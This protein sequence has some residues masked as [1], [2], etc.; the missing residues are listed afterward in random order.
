MDVDDVGEMIDVWERH[1]TK[2]MLKATPYLPAYARHLGRFRGTD[3]SLL[4][5]G[6]NRG[7]SL[8][9]WRA[10]LG[11]D[12]RLVGADID[13]ACAAHTDEGATILIGDQGDRGFL[14][15]LAALGPFDVV[16]D[17]GGHLAS[18]QT[19]TF[20]GLWPAVKP[21]GVYVCEDTATSYLPA[22]RDGPTFM[23]LVKAKVDEMHAWFGG[24]PTDFTRT[25]ASIHVYG[26]LVAIEKDE[27]D[28][29]EFLGQLYGFE[30][31]GIARV[32]WRALLG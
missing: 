14:D 29:P 24:E 27:V 30:A 10:W 9:F 17:D 7:G 23:E 21:G 32:P 5:V 25:A 26:S 19:A 13:P 18:Q 16:I 4:E 28:E 8:Q 12:V 31:G 22:F 2:G 1:V 20:E 3:A 15:E 11:P 6:V